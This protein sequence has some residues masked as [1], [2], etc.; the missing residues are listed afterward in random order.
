LPASDAF[1]NDGQLSDYSI[2]VFGPHKSGCPSNPVA[3][4][5]LVIK[6]KP[7][8][9]QI[10][11]RQTVIPGGNFNYTLAIANFYSQPVLA[12]SLVLP[13]LATVLF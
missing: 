2:H 6:P 3:L 4:A 9:D 8:E 11:Y 10:P 13:L 12:N 5:P 7:Q 1:S